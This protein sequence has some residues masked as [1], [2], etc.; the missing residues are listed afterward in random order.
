[1]SFRRVLAVKIPTCAYPTLLPGC[2]FTGGNENPEPQPAD[3]PKLFPRSTK[4]STRQPPHDASME[5]PHSP[6][7]VSQVRTQDDLGGWDLPMAGFGATFPNTRAD[8]G[9]PPPPPPA[10]G[11]RGVFP[12][13]VP[14]RR[15]PLFRGAPR[16]PL[17]KG[18][19][20]SAGYTTPHPRKHSRHSKGAAKSPGTA[21]KATPQGMQQNEGRRP[22]T[23]A[24]V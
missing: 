11:K 8:G 22:R 6:S 9:S 10:A 2:W 7:S 12:S 15:G 1:V 16:P 23:P 14:R 13:P 5:M 3:C 24:A 21:R 19:P 18:N 4:R 17:A 20:S